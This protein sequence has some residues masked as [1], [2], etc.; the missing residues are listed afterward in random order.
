MKYACTSQGCASQTV[1]NV[2]NEKKERKGP[3]LKQ[4]ALPELTHHNCPDLGGSFISNID[5]VERNG[6]RRL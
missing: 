1:S 6:T 2:R 5:L 3:E 4:M